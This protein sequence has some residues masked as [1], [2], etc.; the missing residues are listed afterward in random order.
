MNLE[1]FISRDRDRGNPA[2]S[3]PKV[4][5]KC[6]MAS[7][8]LRSR[9][10]ESCRDSL[11]SPAGEEVSLVAS[12]QLVALGNVAV[13]SESP[14]TVQPEQSIQTTPQ[15]LLTQEMSTVE[16]MLVGFMA[17]IQ[18]SLKANN[19]NINSVR[20]DLSENINSVRAELST[21]NENINSMRADMNTNQEHVKAEITKIR[22]DIQAENEKVI[23]NFEARNQQTKQEFSAKLDAEARR[24]TNLVGQVQRET[25]AE[26]VGVKGQM[27]AIVTDLSQQ[28]QEQKSEVN[29]RFDRLG[30]DLDSRLTQQKECFEQVTIQEKSVF[31]GHLETVTA[32]IVALENK[33][34]ELP[35]SSVVTEPPAANPNEGYHSVAPLSDRNREIVNGS[36]VQTDGNHTCSCQENS[37]NE[38]SH[39]RV[40]ASRMHGSSE[41]VL[42]SSFLST[43]ELPLPLFDDCSDKNPVLHLRRLD[44]YIRLKGIPKA[45]QLAVAYRSIVG[46]MSR[47]WV[48]TVSVNLQD[49]EEFKTEFLRVWWSQSKQ[50]LMR[51]SLYQ[52]KYNRSSNLSLSGYFLKH[53]T[54]ASYLDPRPSHVEIIEAI[55]YHYPIG[56]Q[57]AMLSN[58]L[59]T[60]EATLELLR[61]VELMESSEGFHRP[62]QPQQQPQ[63]HPNVPRQIQQGG[64]NDRRGQNQNVRQIQFSP[65]RNR[66]NG[67]RWHNG[68]RNQHDRARECDS[69]GST[70]LNPNAPSF[71][72]SREQ[73]QHS[74]N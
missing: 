5:N 61:R 67:N 72:E 58:H 11:D 23:K 29:S 52:G 13:E 25:E 64:Q 24:M 16:Q 74:E 65:H 12:D 8:S 63:H 41:N 47:Q 55:R 71:Q 40:N 6:N 3:E 26:L 34:S 35:R 37:C 48:E 57:R 36:S 51:C 30:Q 70:R 4:S 50:A 22:K 17:T 28:I 31:E 7:R 66:Y 42:V 1:N 56:V 2:R 62:H 43:S 20:S 27:Q 73:G 45:L 38:C 53:A 21:N 10:A 15:E 18:A 39:C 49:Y 68:N 9:T 54:M 19:E 46:Q 14:Q 33:I 32:K 69:S 44:E 59:Q 60:I